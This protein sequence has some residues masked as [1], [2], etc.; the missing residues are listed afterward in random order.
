VA[1]DPKEQPVPPVDYRLTL[2]PQTSDVPVA[3]RLRRL[4][5]YALRQCS[6]KNMGLETVPR[7]SERE[8]Q[9]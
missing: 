2:R 7:Q 5:K 4:L 8:V 3:I 6:L 9:E 1:T